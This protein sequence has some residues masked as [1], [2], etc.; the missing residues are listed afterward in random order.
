MNR[1]FNEVVCPLFLLINGKYPSTLQSHICILIG[2][3]S[4]PH[5][6]SKSI[7]LTLMK[8]DSTRL[9]PWGH[10]LSRGHGFP[11]VT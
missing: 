6:L 10:V 2:N 11:V 4:F 8:F 3:V 1:D 5:S 9:V 7:I